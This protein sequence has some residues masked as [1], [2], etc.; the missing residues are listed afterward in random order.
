LLSP[1]GLQQVYITEFELSR[2]LIASP[3]IRN[4]C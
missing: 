4:R 1:H 3:L 2:L